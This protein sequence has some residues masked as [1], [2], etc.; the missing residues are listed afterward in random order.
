MTKVHAKTIAL[1]LRKAG[2]SYNYIA[3][4]AGV[5]KSTL[6]VWLAD[7]PYTPNA[8]TIARIGNARAASGAA[9]NK[10][11]RVSIMMAR[12]EALKELGRMTR[13]DIFM[14]GLGLYIGEGAKSTAM[15]AFANSN[16]A[17]IILMIKWLEVL[18]LKKANLRL[19]IHLYP[20]CNE[21]ESLQ[22]WSRMTTIP[23]SQFRKTSIDRRTDK[24]IVKAGKLP[25]G[26]A[27]LI[28]NS[29]G[30]KRFGVFLARKMMAWSDE[31]LKTK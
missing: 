15:V 12:D 6:G 17:V 13:R 2:H 28:V 5:S 11:K 16:P 7:V 14:L 25:H 27:H 1:E 29:L 20:D 4:I 9:K 22:Y 10:I 18:G 19:C 31:V 21:K 3:P 30:E 24:K 8:E 23:R 26:T